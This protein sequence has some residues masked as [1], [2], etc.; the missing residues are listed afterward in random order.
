MFAE[1]MVIV[2][3]PMLLKCFYYISCDWN[4]YVIR[5]E[6]LSSMIYILTEILNRKRSEPREIEAD[7][8]RDI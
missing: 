1:D 3:M 5:P 4:V 7:G 6:I 2:R 8:Y